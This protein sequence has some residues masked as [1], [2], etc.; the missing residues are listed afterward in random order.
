VEVDL[1]GQLSPEPVVADQ[2]QLKAFRHGDAQRVAE[3]RLG[4]GLSVREKD[5]VP[6]VSSGAAR[7]NRDG[8]TVADAVCARRGGEVGRGHGEGSV[9][10]AWIPAGTGSL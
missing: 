5:S 9:V 2:R 3:R 4:V 1:H 8:L 6:P 10:E 7:R